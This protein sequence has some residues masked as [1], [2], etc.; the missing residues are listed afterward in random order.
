MPRSVPTDHPSLIAAVRRLGQTARTWALVM[1]GMGALTFWGAEGSYRLAA[2]LW[3]A[4]A[5]LLLLDLQPAHLAL[6]AIVWGVS[7]LQFLPAGARLLGPDPLISIVRPGAAETI[8]LALVRAVLMITA[9]NQF[10]FYRMLYGTVGSTG[11]DP[12]LPAIPEVVVNLTHRIATASLVSG[13]VAGI[14]AVLAVGLPFSQ[15]PPLMT[16][17]AVLA[18]LAIGLG[19]GA[20]FSPTSRRGAALAGTFLGTLAIIAGLATF[21]QAG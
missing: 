18:G 14:A 6:A 20:A 7:L 16:L 1:A 2:A 8:G 10:L 4:A 19:I 21:G 11:L 3:L 12:S 15:S 17:C 5:A 13:G 9:W